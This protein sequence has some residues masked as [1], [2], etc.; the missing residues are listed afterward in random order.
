MSIH[1]TF[2][3]RA[4]WYSVFNAGRGGAHAKRVPRLSYVT[5]QNIDKRHINAIFLNERK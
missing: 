4:W 1:I 3:L 5:D 2:A